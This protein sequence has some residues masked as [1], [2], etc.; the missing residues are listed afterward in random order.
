[1]ATNNPIDSLD[2]IQVALG[3][4]GNSTLTADGILYG[5]GTAAIGITSAGTS[6]QVLLSGAGSA[7]PFWGSVSGAGAINFIEYLD[8]TGSSAVTSFTITSGLTSTYNNY[9][10]TLLG[11]LTTGTDVIAMQVSTNGGSS[12][13]NTGYH[14]GGFVPGTSSFT[15]NNS[16]TYFA[17]TSSIN[18]FNSTFFIYNMN[19]TNIM[20]TGEVNDVNNTASPVNT[21][22]SINTGSINAIKVYTAGGT[23]FKYRYALYGISG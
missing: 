10:F 6:G 15:N 11:N 13:I 19:G 23:T 5:N 1:M 9:I 7:A 17:L 14:S 21:S 16:T 3:G 18:L 2:P 20:F 12:Y 22:G 4:T 8:E